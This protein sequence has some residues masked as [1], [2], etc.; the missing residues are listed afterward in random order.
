[1]AVN[2]CAKRCAH[3]LLL[4]SCASCAGAAAEAVRTATATKEPD[5]ETV[6]VA[7]DVDVPVQGGVPT[8][9]SYASAHNATEAG[10]KV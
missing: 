9:V 10:L 4:D 7:E 8:A 2:A 1:M 3:L 6:A 5:V